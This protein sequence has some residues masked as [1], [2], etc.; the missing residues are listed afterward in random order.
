M[1][2]SAKKKIIGRKCTKND[3]LLKICYVTFPNPMVDEQLKLL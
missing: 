1:E 2:E 3:I